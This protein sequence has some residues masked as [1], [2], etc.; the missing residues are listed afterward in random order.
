MAA[1]SRARTWPGAADTARR[2]LPR[3][4]VRL[5]DFVQTYANLFRSWIAAEL[6]P[7]RLTPWIPVCF[8]SGIAIYFAAN[9]EPLLWAALVLAAVLALGV[10]PARAKPIAFPVMIGVAAIA[11]G[12]ATISTKTTFIEHPVLRHAVGNIE[13]A[14]WVEVREVR[15]RTDRIVVKVHRIEGRNLHD[16]LQR[17]RLSVRK[18]AGP[19]VGSFVELKARLNAPLE[20]LRPGGYDFSRDL[21][22]QKIGATGFAVGEIKIASAPIK[23]GFWVKYAEAIDQMRGAIDR[24]IRAVAPGDTGAIASA[25]ITGTRD[26]LAGPLNDAMYISSL[27]H[28]LSISGYHMAVVAGVVFFFVRAGLALIPGI[29]LRHP[30]K[31]W[32]AAAALPAATFYL[33]LSGAEVAT[34]RSYYMTALVLIGVMLDRPVLTFRTLAIAAMAVLVLA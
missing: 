10:V 28:V 7:G 29:A 30:I 19:A 23:A 27:A 20:P 5:A 12:F 17:V 6:A 33:L 14:G 13:I 2:P 1:R 8:G 24:R 32:A 21:Y 4:P 11:A 15:E 16:A 18:G 3:W 26:A 34:Q 22:F 31:K 25:L 9:Q